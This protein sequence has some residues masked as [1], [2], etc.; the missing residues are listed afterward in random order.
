MKINDI[1]TQDKGLGDTV[2]RVLDKVG[3]EQKPGDC[4]CKKRQERLNKFLAYGKKQ[5]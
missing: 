1:M 4:G 2:K 3:I 5:K